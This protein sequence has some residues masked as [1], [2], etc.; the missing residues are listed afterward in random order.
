M[1][2]ELVSPLIP[3]RVLVVDI[4]AV[5]VAVVI[6]LNH[7]L[8]QQKLLH[9]YASR[10]RTRFPESPYFPFYEAESYILR[11]P[12]GCPGYQV[13]ELLGEVR[14]LAQDLPPDPRRDALLEVVRR[15]EEMVGAL[16][17]FGGFNFGPFGDPFGEM[18]FGDDEDED[19]FDDDGW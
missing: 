8:E 1:S 6:E 15:R 9:Q 13:R 2:A 4:K 7:R 5:I 14:R 17:A 12:Y 16:G 11:G 10:G 18:F 19:E 3:R